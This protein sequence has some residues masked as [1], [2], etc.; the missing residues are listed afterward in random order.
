MGTSCYFLE[1]CKC[2]YNETE[3]DFGEIKGKK[4]E[5]IQKEKDKGKPDKENGLIK[6][7]YE[8]KENKEKERERRERREREEREER[9]RKEREEEERKKKEKAKII[10]QIKSDEE[11]ELKINLGNIYAPIVKNIFLTT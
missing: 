8:T 10:S 4:R 11:L 6:K 7:K 9:E 3:L 1:N 5:E 2:Y